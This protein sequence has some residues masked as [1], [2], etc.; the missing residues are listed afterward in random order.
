[1]KKNLLQF[2]FAFCIIV[3]ASFPALAFSSDYDH[4]F[5]IVS[6]WIYP[7][8]CIKEFNFALDYD[9]YIYNLSCEIVGD[10]TDDYQKL[11]LIYEW[12]TNNIYYDYARYNRQ[13]YAVVIT[14]KDHDR[15]T[16][17]G[18]ES[19][20]FEFYSLVDIVSRRGI[21]DDYSL[22]L[23]DLLSAQGI[24]CKIVKGEVKGRPEE[25]DWNA[26]FV[27]GRW[28]LLDATWDC[29]NKYIA[30]D[31]YVKGRST[32]KYFDISL[33]DMSKDHYFY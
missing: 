11:R 16:A 17:M 12:I 24:P 30:D 21:C 8:Q 26:A 31:T 25:H 29:G 7:D 9:K 2:V 20:S 14:E 18:I 4:N 33:E 27:D 13:G 6:N 23:K 22:Y 32:K 5:Q 28:V 10:E 3:Q 19:N 15:L 1:M